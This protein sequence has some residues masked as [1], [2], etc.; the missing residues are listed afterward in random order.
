[1]KEKDYFGAKILKSRASL[2]AIE[3]QKLKKK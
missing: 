3:S 1:M 2:K